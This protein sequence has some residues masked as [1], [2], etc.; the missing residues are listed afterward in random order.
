MRPPS[1]A[2]DHDTSVS[3]AIDQENPGVGPGENASGLDQTG[4]TVPFDR[5]HGVHGDRLGF[6]RS[7][8]GIGDDWSAGA[9]TVQNAQGWGQGLP[10]SGRHRSPIASAIIQAF[11]LI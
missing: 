5:G 11:Y 9:A 10:T 7:A 8:R 6:W 4:H 2:G 1:V 3:I